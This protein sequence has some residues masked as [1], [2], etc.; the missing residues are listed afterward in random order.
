MIYLLDTSGLVRLLRDAQ[1]QSAWYDAIDAGA[2]A[3]CYAQRTEFLHSARTGREYD[4]IVEMFTDL[5]PDVSV[6]KNAGRW[7]GGVQHRMAQAGEHRSA[8]AVDLVIA[9]TAAH[10][11]LAVLHD[12]ADYRAIAR[13]ASDLTEHNVHDVS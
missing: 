5:Y 9:A 2:I 10:H 6:P 12:D 11:G 7:I 13:H 1:L 8:S 4:E 3:S